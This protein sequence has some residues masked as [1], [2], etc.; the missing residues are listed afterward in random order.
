MTGNLER[1]MDALETKSGM[2]S[3]APILAYCLKPMDWAKIRFNKNIQVILFR[4][5]ECDKDR[6]E[7]LADIE[8]LKT[9]GVHVSVVSQSDGWATWKDGKCI[10]DGALGHE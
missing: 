7:R 3:Q 2:S 10:K 6:I 9:S 5:D 4:P 8:Q 1:R